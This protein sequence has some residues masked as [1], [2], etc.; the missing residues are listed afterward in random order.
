MSFNTLVSIN[1]SSIAGATRSWAITWHVLIRLASNDQTTQPM[2]SS[3]RPQLRQICGIERWDNKILFQSI[4]QFVRQLRMKLC[5][6]NLDSVLIARIWAGLSTRQL[7]NKPVCH[8]YS[9]LSS[10]TQASCY[11]LTGNI[12][13]HHRSLGLYHH[14]ILNVTK[15]NYF[16]IE[17]LMVTQH[18]IEMSN[19]GWKGGGLNTITWNWLS[20]PGSEQGAQLSHH[21]AIHCLIASWT[22]C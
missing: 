8:H 9:W 7:G 18:I 17:I 1:F 16:W 10:K 13:T 12:W 2:R 11:C 20:C 19:N 21:G 22:C 3:Y 15:A 4:C 6:R 5:D 14:Q